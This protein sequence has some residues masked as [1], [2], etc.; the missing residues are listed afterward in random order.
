CYR[1]NA[2]ARIVDDRG[3]VVAIVNNYRW[4]SFDFGPTLTAWM[5]DHAPDVLERVREADK[6]GHGAIAQAFFHSILP[7]DDERDLR[8]NLRWG[9]ADFRHRFGREAEGI[10][11]PETAVDDRV[12]AVL[13]EEGVRFTIL[14]PGQATAVRPLGA[15]G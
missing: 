13:A 9:L 1:P 14:A 4:L 8:T 6:E 12:L 15:K 7:L 3:G 2:H 11:L 5:E 10:W